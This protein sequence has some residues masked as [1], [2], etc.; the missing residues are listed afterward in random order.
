MAGTITGSRVG[1][2]PYL[3]LVTTMLLWGS[4][5]S[6]SKV[7][8]DHL[9]H[10]VVAVLRFGGGALTLL[11]A[12]R[13]SRRDG[14][15]G[16]RRRSSPQDWAR[17]AG[18]GVLGVFV[19]NLLFF[20][21]LSLA[22]AIDG[23][24][25]VP[26]MSPVLT[27]AFLLVT[28]Q[29]KAS[30]ARVAGLACGAAGAAI[31]FVGSGGAA[32]GGQVRLAGDLLFLLSA[33]CW[34]GFTLLGRRVL[35]GIEPLR[36]TTYATVSGAVLLAIYSAP[37]AVEVAWHDVPAYVWLNV[38]F[39]ALGPTAVANLLYYRGVQAVGP[40]SASIM[41]FLVPVVGTACSA[42]L[43]DESFGAVQAVGAAVLSVGAVLAV[44]QGRIPKRRRA[45]TS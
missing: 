13:L 21:G 18:A 1:T 16:G 40:A 23:S 17:A 10:S 27:T 24:T 8:V 31:F 41:M 43:L 14:E 7:I 34:A 22:P 3:L 19:Y 5:F 11:V 37:A 25:I 20:W 26:V 33:G 38:V 44:T 29:D 12:L 2:R 9:P 45:V 32:G 15:G 6:S 42:L 30:A 28:R 4:G 35:A 39:V 36:A